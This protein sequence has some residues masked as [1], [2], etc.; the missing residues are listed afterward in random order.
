M[1]FIQLRTLQTS[2]VCSAILTALSSAPVYAAEKDNTVNEKQ[3]EHIMVTSRKKEE[4]IIEIPM[5]ISSISGME[6]VDRNYTY[7]RDIYRTLAGAAMPRGELILRGLS[8]GNTAFPNTTAVFTDDIPLEFNNL[9]DIE[10]VEILRGPQGT[11]YGSNAIGGTVRIITKKPVMNEFQLFGSLQSKSEKNV[12]GYDTNFSLGINI[13]LIDDTLALRINGNIDDDKG[14]MVNAF[15]GAQAGAEDNFLRS[16]LLWAPTD[17][18]SINLGF[19]RTEYSEHG[20]FSA[21]RSKPGG[22]WEAIFDENEDSLYGYDIDERFVECDPNLGRPACLS[23]GENITGAKDK[24]TVYDLIDDWYKDKLEIYTLTIAHDNI[25]DIATLT[26]AGSFRQYKGHY[27]TDWSRADADDLF[28]TWIIGED[29]DKRTTHEIRLQNIDVNSSFS[30]TIGMFS[31]KSTT[32]ENP[33]NQWQYHEG[34]DK[35]SALTNYWWGEDVTALGEKEF[36]NPNKNW[37]YAIVENWMNELS[38]FADVSYT[39]ETDSMGKFEFGGGIRR[40]D[41]EDYFH[42]ISTGIWDNDSSITSGQEDGTRLKFSTAWMPS[43]DMSV[44]ALYSEGYRP[45]GN[46]GPLPQSCTDDPKSSSRND[47]YN[48]DQIENKEIGFKASMFNNTFNFTSAIYQIDWTS[49]KTDIY[50]D[51]CGFSYTANGGEARSRGIEFESTAQ[52]TDNLTMTLNTSYTDSYLTL[53]NDAIDGKAGDDMTMIP[54]YNAY[55]AFDQAINIMSKEAYIRLDM[56]AY[57]KYKTH[58]DTL[59]ADEVDSYQVFNLSGRIELSDSVQLS[60]HINNLLD[61]EIVSY[62]KARSRDV[63]SRAAQYIRYL[64]ERNVTVRLDYTFF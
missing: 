18:L 45:G 25:L 2:L 1:S 21:D 58:F 23:G 20:S 12:N 53:D 5:S 11:L 16:Q 26:Y 24:Y 19:V 37:N 44:Y 29:F 59:P 34:G 17:D 50:M 33:N 13:P 39:L 36:G 54:K 28:R 3:L 22:Y 8:G 61:S 43:S 38:F 55:L 30:W 41:L 31:D 51:T 42:S 46:N 57:G 35:V 48:S 32:P 27:L 56:T 49:I 40:Y 10:R 63:E 7:A 9:A 15:T 4:T 6:I 62:Q 64:P 47:R 14:V 52:L 60:V